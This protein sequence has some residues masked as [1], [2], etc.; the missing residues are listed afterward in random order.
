MNRKILTICFILV[1]GLFAAP[2]KM[3]ASSDNENVFEWLNN[4][5]QEIEDKSNTEQVNEEQVNNDSDLEGSNSTNLITIVIRIIFALLLIIGLI[6]GMLKFINKKNKLTSR[7]NIIKNL[8]GIPL[9][10]NKSVQIIQ[11]GDRLFVVGVGENIELLT[12]IKDEETKDTLFAEKTTDNVVTPQITKILG[13]AF[14]HLS[15]KKEKKTDEIS[16]SFSHL[17]KS[18]LNHL[19]QTRSKITNSYKR[20]EEDKNE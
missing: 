8:G 20:K 12:E 18:E 3:V 17:F 1:I 6:Y 4:D 14:E 9:G 7:P 19:K 13:N 16:D 5:T 10:T 2:N 11:I 15:T